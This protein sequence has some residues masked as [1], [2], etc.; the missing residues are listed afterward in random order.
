[1]RL[2]IGALGVWIVDVYRGERSRKENMS[3][4]VAVIFPFSWSSGQMTTKR[5]EVI[6]Y[7]VLSD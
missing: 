6:H 7:H 4:C 3:E 2:L 5:K 1:M